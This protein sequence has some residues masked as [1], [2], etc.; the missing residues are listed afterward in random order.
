M[1]KPDSA[2]FISKGYDIPSDYVEA[3]KWSRLAADR[4]HRTAQLLVGLM[5]GEGLGLPRDYISAHMWL[6]L[7]AGDGGPSGAA[8]Y[9]DAIAKKMAPEDIAKAQ[10]M[11][12]EWKRK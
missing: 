6:D 5:H 4:G 8:N 2:Y 7:A 3:M 1:P 9:R 12:Q 11:A 10:K